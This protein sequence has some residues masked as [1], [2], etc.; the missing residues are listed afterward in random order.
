MN[1]FNLSIFTGQAQSSCICDDG[2]AGNYEDPTSSKE[3]DCDEIATYYEDSDENDKQVNQALQGSRNIILNPQDVIIEPQDSTI[4]PIVSTG[5][6]KESTNKTKDS[7]TEP[8]DSKELVLV[9]TVTDGP[10]T[11]SP[12][13][14]RV[15]NNDCDKDVDK[16]V[17]AVLKKLE[18][19]HYIEMKAYLLVKEMVG[20]TMTE[21]LGSDDSKETIEDDSQSVLSETDYTFHSTF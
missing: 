18:K 5:Q 17:L 15:L 3:C 6:P 19:E 11:P 4:K 10:P 14:S 12:T 16:I 1:I 21:E 8:Q 2:L 13:G 7:T 9:L 20:A